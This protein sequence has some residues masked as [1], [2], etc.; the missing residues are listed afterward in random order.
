MSQCD[1]GVTQR[2]S[3]S[4]NSG[5]AL[6]DR[7]PWRRNEAGRYVDR[8]TISK[9]RSKKGETTLEQE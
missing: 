2:N 4:G 8:L 5:D 1:G 6:E 9:K 3:F 7:R